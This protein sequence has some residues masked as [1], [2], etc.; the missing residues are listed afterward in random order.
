MS[1]VTC[2]LRERVQPTPPYRVLLLLE[3]RLDIGKGLGLDCLRIVL[4]RPFQVHPHSRTN[5]ASQRG[6]LQLL[7]DLL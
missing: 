2:A 4:F 5:L 1:D 7:Q 6:I 3:G